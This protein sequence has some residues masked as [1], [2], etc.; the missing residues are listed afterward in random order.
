MTSAAV[1][2]TPQDLLEWH[3][4]SLSR[5]EWLM[6]CEHQLPTRVINSTALNYDTRGSSLS[7]ACNFDSFE[8]PPRKVVEEPS[9][10]DGNQQS[11]VYPVQ[12]PDSDML[13]ET[14]TKP[15]IIA[16]SSTSSSWETR[17]L[18]EPTESHADYRVLPGRWKTGKLIGSGSFGQVFQGLN[19]DTG[20]IIAIKTMFLPNSAGGETSIKELKQMRT[21]IELMSTLS[22]PN[23]VSY[24]GAEVDQ[25]SC[26]LHIFQEWVPGGSLSSVLKTFGGTFDDVVTR[27]YLGDCLRGLEYLHNHRIAHRD[28]KGENVLVS[29]DGVAKLADMGASKRVS[30]D[31]TMNDSTQVRGTPYYMSPEQLKQERVGRKADIW[32]LGGLALLMATG[33][34][35]WKVLKISSPYALMLTQLAHCNKDC[36]FHIRRPSP[37]LGNG[38]FSTQIPGHAAQLRDQREDKKTRLSLTVPIALQ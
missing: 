37:A 2:P 5:D 12:V 6:P 20:A 25:A 38:S 26:K 8:C 7:E 27:K 17:P 21:E 24:L 16:T 36:V 18:P 33:D 13:L 14:T 10:D 28:I 30:P 1:T 35:P 32:A 3:Q 9:I 34:P 11:L 4:Q 15:R 31:G 19:L 29:H 23:I 22:H